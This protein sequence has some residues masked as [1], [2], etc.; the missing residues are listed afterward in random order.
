MLRCFS[1]W[2]EQ[3]DEIRDWMTQGGTQFL[4]NT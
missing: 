4:P 2:I 1:Q 3:L